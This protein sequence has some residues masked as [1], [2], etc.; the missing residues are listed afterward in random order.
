MQYHAG[1]HTGEVAVLRQKRSHLPLL[2]W[3]ERLC[4]EQRTQVLVEV[5]G[6]LVGGAA[7]DTISVNVA[8]SG[9][10]AGVQSAHQLAQV[11]VHLA[12]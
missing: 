8:K 10:V 7:P 5:G 9:D 6:V 2:A 3:C 11:E 4:G 1:T 12:A